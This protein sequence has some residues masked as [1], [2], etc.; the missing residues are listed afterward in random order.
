MPV[1]KRLMIQY[2]SHSKLG[3]FADRE[4]DCLRCTSM[5]RK[6]LAKDVAVSNVR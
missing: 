5:T 1:G 6:Y 3:S 4:L 2:A